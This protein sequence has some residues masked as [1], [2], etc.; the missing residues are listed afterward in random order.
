M[1]TSFDLAAVEKFIAETNSGYAALH[2]AFEDQFWGTKMNLTGIPLTPESQTSEPAV[3]KAKVDSIYSTELLTKTKQEMEDFLSDPVKLKTCRDHRA[4]L[5]GDASNDKHESIKKVLAIF[6]R[7]FC[8]YIME[9]AEAKTLREQGM[10]LENE[11]N[12]KRNQ[13]KLGATIDGVFVALSSVGLRN[14]LKTDNNE[15]TRKAC[16][17]GLTSIGD[18]I[19]ANGFI[20]V[21]K[22]RNEMARAL[23]FEDY[24]EYKVTN[25]EGFGKK[26]LFAMLD[27][28]E[29]STRGLMTSSREQFAVKNGQDSLQPWN[30]N[31]AMSGDITAKLDPYFPFSKAVEMW[32]R[33]YHAMGIRYKQATMDLDLLDR[34]G[35][36]S[37]GFCHWPVC[38]WTKPDGSWQPSTAHFTSLAD[39]NAVGSGL[40][41]LTTLMHEAG[42]AAHFANITQPSPLFAQERAPTSVAY[43]ET[44][45]MFLDS[46]VDDAAWRARYA[47]N[48]DG[49]A[50]PWNLIEEDIRAKHPVSVFGLRS[51]LAVPYFEKA[52]YEME[53]D[54]LSAETIK[55]LAQD[56]ELRI[57]GG[58]GTRPLLSVPHIISD[59][60]SCYY[61]G[62][63]LAEMAVHQTREW[64]MKKYGFIVDNEAV[65]PTLATSYWQC[66]NSES[67]LDLVKNLTG[68]ELDGNSW[69]NY[70]TQDLDAK[71]KSEREEY[72]KALAKRDDVKPANI[73]LDMTVRFVDGDVVIADTSKCGGLVEACA[74][75]SEFISSRS[76]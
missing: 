51:M 20:E 62:Y 31:H 27:T 43:A 21:V 42:H 44:Q 75:F 66:G 72:N 39:P 35:K 34:S 64:F 6:E 61:H 17:E 57:Q 68:T 46:L 30:T 41:A 16:Y 19:L 45:S 24:Y 63:V 32:G 4:A 74:K 14:K 13:L 8:C 56:I 25:A 23:G 48:T 26:R 47:S 58:P 38:A 12:S 50:I 59:E 11:L 7:T 10:K 55:A 70:L 1:S 15:A 53:S 29:Q 28:L 71:L 5:D 52:L 67:F 54:K 2:E 76:N 40:T 73:D 9:S 60:A 65:G 18:F 3:K 49:A 33:S 69:T 22:K 37:N 36:Y